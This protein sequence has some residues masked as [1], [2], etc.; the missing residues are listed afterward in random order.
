MHTVYTVYMYIQVTVH[1]DLDQAF[2]EADVILLLDEWHCDGS[3][4]EEEKIN[5]VSERYRE[6][7]QLIDARANKEANVIVTGSSFVN[8]RCTLLVEHA[9]VIDSHK[10]VAVATELENEAKAVLANKLK[11]RASGRC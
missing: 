4:T 1:T 9:H 7:G 10:F 6:Y 11:V 5:K 8:L 2:L 3:D